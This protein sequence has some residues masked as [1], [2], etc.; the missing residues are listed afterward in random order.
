MDDSTDSAVKEQCG[1]YGR[2]IDIDQEAISSSFLAFHQVVG[3]PTS[4]NIYQSILKLIG[5][6]GLDPPLNKMVAFTCDGAS[7]VISN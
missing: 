3:Y 7:V 2:F 6:D 4:E 5:K 1:V